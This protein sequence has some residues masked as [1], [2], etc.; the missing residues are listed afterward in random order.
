MRKLLALLLS[1]VAVLALAGCDPLA[2][3]P[4][5]ENAASCAVP[6]VPS[7]SY[8]YDP[9][10]SERPADVRPGN[11]WIV[12]ELEVKALSPGDLN[13]EYCVPIGVHVYNR[14]GEADTITIND[15]G[16]EPGPFDFTASTPW[17]GRYVALQYDPTE[18]RFAGRPPMYEVHVAATYLRERDFNAHDV[19]AE[20]VAIECRIRIHGA[21]VA[22]DF[23]M[24]GD[25][26]NVSCTFRGNDFWQHY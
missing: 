20:P 9:S 21:S 26:D 12:L 2:G 3:N 13:T 18:E 10:G 11:S 15:G 16:V 5:E 8:S 1:G 17:T 4:I 19:G 22:E 7:T 14:T 24:M 25:R 23:V 6:R